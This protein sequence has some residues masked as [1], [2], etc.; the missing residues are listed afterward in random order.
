MYRHLEV[1]GSKNAKNS[2]IGQL[3]TVTGYEKVC[4]ACRAYVTCNLCDSR[5]TGGARMLLM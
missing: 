1:F 3:E 5:A 4:Y 2:I